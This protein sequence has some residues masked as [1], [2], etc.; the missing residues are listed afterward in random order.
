MSIIPN[1][2]AGFVQKKSMTKIKLFSVTCEFWIHLKC[3]NL[4]YLDYRYLQNCDESCYC[5]ECCS[6]IYPFNS[7]SINKNLLACC[8]TDSNTMQ[9]KY[10]E[11]DHDSSLLLKLS[12]NLEVLVNLI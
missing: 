3:N 10:P 7:L 6:R 1:F 12:P 4:N 8:T 11:N 2:L 9:W 5:I